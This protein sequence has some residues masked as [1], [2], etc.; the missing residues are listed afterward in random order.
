MGF[1]K[2]ISLRYLF[3]REHKLLVS[4][5]TVISILGVM[6]GVSA[7]ITVISVMDG[8]DSELIQKMIGTF[9]HIDISPSFNANEGFS[10]HEKIID[11][12]N[13][14]DGVVAAA[15]LIERDVAVQKYQKGK[16]IETQKAV[17]LIRGVNFQQEKEVTDLIKNVTY[18]DPTPGEKEIVLGSEAAKLLNA[19][20]GDRLLIISSIHKTAMGPFPVR[21]LLTVSGIFKTGFYDVDFRMGYCSLDTARRIFRMEKTSVD[22]IHMKVTNPSNLTSVKKRLESL[23]GSSFIV[24]G[25]NERSPGFFHALRMEKLAMFII[26]LL[27]ILVAAFNIIGTQIMVVT[28]KTR[29]IGILK[30]MGA[31]KSSIR[32]IFL[33][34]G[35]MI[36]VVGT[37]LGIVLGLFLCYLIKYHIHYDLPDA[38]YGLDTLP[39]KVKPFMLAVIAL[40]SLTICTVASIIPAVQAARLDPVEALRYE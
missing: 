21:S 10:Y 1:E 17:L 20:L 31:T 8:F 6:V 26:L 28:Q 5:I 40:C 24:F 23:L 2:F 12:L 18:G 27:I 14:V 22:R 19:Y 16:N 33:F 29:E 3:T 32:K 15:P 7:L 37:T 11:R 9:S 39:V 25:W 4:I 34:H 38:I 30:S 35:L 36:G 13:S